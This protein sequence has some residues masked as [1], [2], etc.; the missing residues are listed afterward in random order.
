MH[1]VH[2]V[3]EYCRAIILLNPWGG[4]LALFSPFSHVLHRPHL[5]SCTLLFPLA[6]ILS[7]FLCCKLIIFP[8]FP[9]PTMRQRII[10]KSGKLNELK[11]FC[12]SSALRCRHVEFLRQLRREARQDAG[13][14]ITQINGRAKIL[15]V[16][17]KEG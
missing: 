1:I 10:K 15:L 2:L 11:T 12:T 6:S 16:V 3:F 9:L 8:P 13:G 7:L 5:A 4:N 17:L 14:I